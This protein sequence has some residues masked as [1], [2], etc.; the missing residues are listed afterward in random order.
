M[1]NFPFISAGAVGGSTAM[2]SV[3]QRSPAISSME[4][5]NKILVS[6]SKTADL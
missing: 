3:A 5:F 4:S 2:T 6:E 1:L